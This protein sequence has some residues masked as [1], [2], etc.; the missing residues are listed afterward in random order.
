MM[1]GK[2]SGVK[3]LTVKC[4]LAVRIQMLS[5]SIST[6]RS[7][8]YR[9]F[10]RTV[11]ERAAGEQGQLRL[12]GWIGNQ[13]REEAGILVVYVPNSMRLPRRK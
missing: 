13:S 6:S 12:T 11:L 5:R 2:L 1:K 10:L 8:G 7:Q 9:R 3:G 4:H